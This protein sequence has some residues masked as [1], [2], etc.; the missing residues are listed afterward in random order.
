MSEPSTNLTGLTRHGYFVVQARAQAM[1]AT[2][3]LSGVLENLATGDKRHFHSPEEL[4]GL[5]TAWGYAGS[6]PTATE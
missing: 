2:V 3:I 6:K 4:S 5:F 1:G